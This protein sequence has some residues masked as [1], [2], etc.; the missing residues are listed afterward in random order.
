MVLDYSES[1]SPSV[2]SI[3][4]SSVVILSFERPAA[5][6]ISSFVIGN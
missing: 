4:R 2:G 3:L 1:L 6:R 5:F